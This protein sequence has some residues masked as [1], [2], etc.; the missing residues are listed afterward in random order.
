MVRYIFQS[1]FP[2]ISWIRASTAFMETLKGKKIPSNNSPSGNWKHLLKKKEP[3]GL[4]MLGIIQPLL[5][6]PWGS[7]GP[8]SGRAVVIWASCP[9]DKCML[10]VGFGLERSSTR[11]CRQE[12]FCVLITANSPTEEP[13]LARRK[14]LLGRIQIKYPGSTQGT[15][16]ISV[17]IISFNS[18]SCMPQRY[19]SRIHTTS[20]LCFSPTLLLFWRYVPAYHV[21]NQ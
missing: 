20:T 9:G 1:F 5:P 19:H 16:D 15:A 18:T 4:W 10:L 13:K 6:I 3:L 14:V 21:P 11:I 8:F 17:S 2:P 7:N 12:G